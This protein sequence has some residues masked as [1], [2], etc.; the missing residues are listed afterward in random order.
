MPYYK[1]NIERNGIEIYFD[2]KPSVSV[3][4]LLKNNGWRWS[5]YSKCWYNYYSETHLK[6]AESIC[7]KKVT[8]IISHEPTRKSVPE[9]KKADT[10]IKRTP[11][12]QKREVTTPIIQEQKS[13]PVF[14]VGRQPFSEGDYCIISFEDGKKRAGIVKNVDAE[15][16]KAKLEYIVSI[17]NGDKNYN[18]GW[19]DFSNLELYSPIFS[20][21]SIRKGQ[22]VSFVTEDGTLE[23]GEITDENYDDTYDIRYFTVYDTG[24]I[25]E[26]TNYSVDLDRIT[27]I[28]YGV[29]IFPV[30]VGDKVEYKSDSN[31]VVVARV[32][33]ISYDGTLT[34]EYSYIDRW[35]E[36]EREKEYGVTLSKIRL[37]ARGRKALDRTAYISED[38]QKSIDINEK[39]KERIKDRS[40]AF[41]DARGIFQNRILYRHQKAGTI[42]ADMYD[43]SYFA[44]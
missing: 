29:N 21:Y 11:V 40:D 42:L 9:Q 22:I 17:D 36:R 13:V 1:R 8:D 27:S 32:E 44:C 15:A 2:H 18:S 6:F 38:K 26:T 4:D 37:M 35:G 16:E 28:E 31:G 33:Y 7:D 14:K 25:E 39:I 43:N 12:I 23:K 5:G 10:V 41:S 24:A 30:K 3:R 34:V 19:F 20:S